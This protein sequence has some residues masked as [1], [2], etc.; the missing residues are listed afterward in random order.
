LAVALNIAIIIDSIMTKI[1]VFG[2]DFFAISRFI[3]LLQ[4]F[5]C[6]KVK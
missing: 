3:V 4:K 2:R 6:L 1:I 5:S